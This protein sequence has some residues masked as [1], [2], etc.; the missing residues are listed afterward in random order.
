MVDYGAA[1]FGGGAAFSR[2]GC[3]VV[4]YAKAAF[5]NAECAAVA[6]FDDVPSGQVGDVV[7]PRTVRGSPSCDRCRLRGDSGKSRKSRCA[8]KFDA[9]SGLEC[10]SHGGYSAGGGGG[11]KEE[12]NC[13]AVVPIPTWLFVC[14]TPLKISGRF[15]LQPHRRAPLQG[16]RQRLFSLWWSPVVRGGFDVHGCTPNHLE[17]QQQNRKSPIY[18]LD[19]GTP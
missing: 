10:L 18:F 17:G 5:V 8:V 1:L 3:P 11:Q 16:G 15:K 2:S 9:R 13:L 12:G 14:G 7:F 19:N 6:E 4:G